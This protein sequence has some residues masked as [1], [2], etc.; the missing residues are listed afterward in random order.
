VPV[1]EEVQ[2]AEHLARVGHAREAQ[3]RRDHQ[4]AQ[5]G[6]GHA[7]S[8]RGPPSIRANATTSAPVLM[9]VIVATMALFE[10]RL[11][12]QM[13]C[14]LVQPPPRRVPKPTTAPAT[15]RTGRAA[16]LT[17]NAPGRTEAKAI[18]PAIRP[19]TK[20]ARQPRSPG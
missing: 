18:P 9:K 4:P 14:P 16:W 1:T 2:E 7:S 5:E 20:A 13:P 6:G 15:S 8:H 17:A 19:A 10:S 12:P 11:T 3:A